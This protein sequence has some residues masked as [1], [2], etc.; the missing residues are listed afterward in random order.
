[1]KDVIIVDP[2]GVC[3]QFERV[4][5]SLAEEPEK[6]DLCE[7]YNEDSGECRKIARGEQS[8]TLEEE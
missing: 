2:D 1:M 5:W 6:C 8:V 7:Y 4:A 3:W